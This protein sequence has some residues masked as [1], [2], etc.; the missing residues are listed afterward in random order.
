VEGADGWRTNWL[1]LG[2]IV[3]AVAVVCLRLIRNSPSEMGLTPVGSETAPPRSF[4]RSGSI[5][6]KRIIH[7]LGLVYFLFGYTYVIY[8]TFFVTS[9][10]ND[11][12]MSEAD[13]GGLWSW[14]G[15]LSL[16]SGPVFGTLSDKVGRRAAF[17]TVFLFQG[18][19]YLIVASGLPREFLPL[20]VLMCGV[21]AWSIPSIMAAAVGDY[22]GALRAPEAFGFI[23]FIFALGQISGPA[24]AGVMAERAG[25]FA[26]S[27]LMAAF[28]A[29]SAALLSL[30]LRRAPQG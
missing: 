1:L 5:Y 9:L 2:C 19:A 6:Q 7:H 20:S 11:W 18:M 10:V 24:V 3:L 23:T 29:G 22:V 13:A 30:F 21:A 28:L 26:G 12:G 14:V 17:A 4:N 16:L 27:F 25:S 8:A 15:V